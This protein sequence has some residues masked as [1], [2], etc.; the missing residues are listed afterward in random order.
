M[1]WI[2]RAQEHSV[3]D[4]T[5]A[6]I[7]YL[8][9]LGQL[10]FPLRSYPTGLG[11]QIHKVYQAALKQDPVAP[12]RLGIA[13][14]RKKSPAQLFDALPCDDTWADAS[15]IS[16]FEYLYACKHVRIAKGFA[17]QAC[18]EQLQ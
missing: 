16:V 7:V 11:V 3:L 18:H 12:L 5:T 8:S 4:S 2:C 15:L 1:V 17:C 10:V 13:V 6:C 9:W 14:D